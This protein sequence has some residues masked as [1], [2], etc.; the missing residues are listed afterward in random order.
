MQRC[1]APIHVRH[2]TIMHINRHSISVSSSISISTS[3]PSNNL[4]LTVPLP[5][6]SVFCSSSARHRPDSSTLLSLVLLLLLYFLNFSS[7]SLPVST[8]PMSTAAL[9]SLLSLLRHPSS[10]SFASLSS[11][12]LCSVVLIQQCIHCKLLCLNG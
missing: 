5:V 11:S 8:V 10:A 2:H 1:A 12:L 6:F 9:H 4:M 3:A 7:T